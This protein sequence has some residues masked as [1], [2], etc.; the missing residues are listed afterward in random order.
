MT[1]EITEIDRQVPSL[2]SSKI[3][4]FFHLSLAFTYCIFVITLLS[5]KSRYQIQGFRHDETAPDEVL[6]KCSMAAHLF[7]LRSGTYCSTHFYL[8]KNETSPHQ[9]IYFL[10]TL[11]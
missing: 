6:L 1:V 4:I 8:W 7:S 5:W 11:V 3:T 9:A 10:I 2:S